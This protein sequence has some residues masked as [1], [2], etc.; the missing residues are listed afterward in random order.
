MIELGDADATVAFGRLIGGLLTPGDVVALEGGLGAGKTTLTRGI[1]EALGL[2]QEAPS[3]TFPV[4]IP[5]EPP[6]VSLPLWHVDLYRIGHD[7]EL[8]ELGLDEVL[9]DG[10]LVV[11]WP[12]RLGS[13][14]LQKAL[15]L[16]LEPGASGGRRLTAQRPP[17]WEQRWPQT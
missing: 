2:T 13:R 4:V 10:A 7:D 3:P 12:Q 6:M 16:H 15:R 9:T 17:S 14:F 1:L 5:Y 11:E 8:E